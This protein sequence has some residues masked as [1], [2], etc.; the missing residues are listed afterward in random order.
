M[1]NSLK[2]EITNKESDAIYLQTGGV[3]WQIST[4]SES[5]KN[6]PAVGQ[7]AKVYIYLYHREDQMRLFGFATPRERALFL[8]LLKVESVGPKLALKILSG[9]NPD[10]FSVALQNEDVDRLAATPGVG[11]KTAQKILL[12]L[13]GRLTKAD[14]SSI[15]FA[16]HDIIEALIG[17]GFDKKSAQKAVYDVL[18]KLKAETFPHEPKDKFERELL[19][20]AIQLISSHT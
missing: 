17:M 19:K 5:L 9:I 3:E 6:L 18:E 12:K 8:D 13:H 14:D 11:K 4:T 15:N 1:F 10:E 7:E 16:H 2:G 20:R